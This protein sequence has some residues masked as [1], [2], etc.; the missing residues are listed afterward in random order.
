[1][2]AATP[3]TFGKALRAGAIA[4]L[5]AAG[6]NNLWSLVAQALGSVPPPGFVFAVCVSSIFPLLVGGVFYFMLMKLF[7]KGALIFTVASCLFLLLSLYP[8]VAPPAPNGLTTTKGFTLLTL[9]MH[10]IAGALGIWGI[11]KFSK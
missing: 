1:M 6:L 8:T 3:V 7:P 10:L 4:G 5:L 2:N 9:P 11:P